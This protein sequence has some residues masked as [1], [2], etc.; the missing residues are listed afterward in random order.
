M[1]GFLRDVG[2]RPER[3]ARD[4]LGKAALFSDVRQP[5]TLVVECGACGE[6]TR[7][8][9]VDF[10]LG[11]PAVLGVAAA[12]P[13]PPVQPPHDLSRVQ[14][15]DLGPRALDA[16]AT[17]ALLSRRAGARAAFEAHAAVPVDDLADEPRVVARRRARRR[18]RAA[19]RRAERSRACPARG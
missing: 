12:A 17:S 4:P 11:E 2:Q 6:S 14:R 18:P 16:V 1:S 9:Y 13:E 15:V 8:S 5:G 3:P 10:A 7:V 19:R